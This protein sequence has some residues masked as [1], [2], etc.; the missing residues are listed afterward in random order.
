VQYIAVHAKI[1]SAIFKELACGFLLLGDTRYNQL[2]VFR[3]TSKFCRQNSIRPYRMLSGRPYSLR[4]P[5][6]RATS[7][8]ILKT[9][10]VSRI[11]IL[12]KLSVKT[13]QN[14][15]HNMY[16]ISHNYMFRPILDHLQVVPY[17]LASV[18]A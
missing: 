14:F 13:Q 17:S 5:L 18:V 12:I 10:N 15:M 3:F 11:S 2:H 9:K 6:L 1:S 7:F 16:N 8:E 4:E